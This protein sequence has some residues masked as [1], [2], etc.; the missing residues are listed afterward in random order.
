[1]K[2][3][4]LLRKGCWAFQ[5]LALATI[6]FVVHQS[7]A[8]EFSK[9]KVIKLKL[10][11]SYPARHP[12][13]IRAFQVWA[14][15][16]EEKSKG[17][18]KITIFSG[19]A[20]AKTREAYNAT[21][22]G[23]CDIAMF[24]QSYAGD[25]FPLSLGMNLPMLFSNATVASRVAWDLY[26][27][28]PEIRA[29]YSDVKVLF[30]Y[31]TSPYE[32]HTVKKPIYT[33]K[34]LKG[35]QIRAA[36]PIAASIMEILGA[37]PV[38]ISMPEAYLA[39]QRGVLD[40]LVSPFGTMRAFKTAD[41]TRYHTV[42]ANL[43]SNIFCVVMNLKKWKNLPPDLQEAIDEVSGAKASRL[44]GTVF[45][46]MKEPDIKYMKKKGDVFVKI[47]AEE[48]AKW[49][50]AIKPIREKWVRKTSAKGLPAK[51]ILS[52]MIRLSKEYSR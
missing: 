36:G 27:E 19:C 9:S 51:E 18:V 12:M 52:E 42:N 41:V 8:K 32:I 24:P 14:K 38:A 10:N 20:L 4:T 45:D 46:S 22:A 48:K 5:L 28:F 34:D 25:R 33:A 40:G 31:C 21:I 26:K 43:F 16:V 17:R 39:L 44:F 35:L 1:M 6:F 30:F 29:E 13:T 7:T 15:R 50:A 47:P 3:K 2:V 37:T 11:D 23:V 49:I